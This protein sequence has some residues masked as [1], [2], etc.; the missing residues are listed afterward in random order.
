LAMRRDGALK[1]L[2]WTDD[3]ERVFA[4]IR[5]KRASPRLLCELWFENA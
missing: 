4:V 2:M 5:T 1:L 3:S